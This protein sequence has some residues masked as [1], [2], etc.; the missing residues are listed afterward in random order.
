M[1]GRVEGLSYRE[2]SLTPPLQW[3][4]SQHWFYDGEVVCF[5]DPGHIFLS[6]LAIIIL[7]ILV[8]LSPA[9]FI[10]TLV[11]NSRM[12]KVWSIRPIC[13]GG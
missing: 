13:R 10:F 9:L 12:V 11:A 8:L 7:T 6:I 5:K 1:C 4:V 3:L 2:A